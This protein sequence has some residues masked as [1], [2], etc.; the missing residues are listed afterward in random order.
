MSTILIVD[1]NPS[2]RKGIHGLIDW[3]SLQI[4]VVGLAIDGL[5]GYRQ[6]VE[7][8]PD[9]V[10]TDVSMPVLDGIKM[11]QKIKAELPET[12][13]IFMSCFDDYE[14]LKGAIDL[15]VYGYILKPIDLQELT[16][17]IEKVKHIKLME[18]EK[19]QNEQQLRQQLQESMPLLQE[20]LIRDLLYG[21]LEDERDI[22]DRMKY[23]GMDFTNKYV[24]VLFLQIDNFDVLYAELS[25]EDRQMMIYSIQKC[26]EET[27]LQNIQGYVTNQQHNSLAI[28][29]MMQD[30]NREETFAAIIDAANRCKETVNQKG[31]HITIGITE[32]SNSLKML[33]DLFQTAEYAVKSKFFGSGNRIIMASEVKEPDT[34]FQYNILEIKR[35]MER[36]V[37]S[38]E[39]K[40]IAAFLDDYYN[41]A[42]LY[43]ETYVKS[44]AFSIAN[45]VQTILIERNESYESVFGYDLDVWNKL[46]R[47][48]TMLDIKDWLFSMINTVRAF[49]NKAANGRYQKIVED[50]K[51]IIDKGYTEIDNV[52]QIVSS[53]YVSASHANFIFKS[54][55]GQ[56]IFDYLIMRRMEA[57]KGML[58]NP[59]MKIYEIAEKS[60]YKTNSYFASVFKEYTGLSPKQFRDRHTS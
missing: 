30:A 48:E 38:G 7:R 57:A 18:A 17:T 26:V 28:I 10:L 16:E 31:I 46:Q 15:E 55:T 53:L 33:P 29:L 50:I 27:I 45:V 42:V 14:Y 35:G 43:P 5:D 37:E 54:Q 40:G 8:K 13:F 1:D 51:E 60:G 9:F 52:S 23:L 44:L 32:F 34:E 2:D 20:Q 58:L 36:L 21:K 49:L 6:A 56:T 4:E 59:E 12:K 25:I 19:K 11:T 3:A 41:T 22:R 39:E 47:F 24:A